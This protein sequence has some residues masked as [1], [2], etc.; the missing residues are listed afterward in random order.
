MADAHMIKADGNLVLMH[1]TAEKER[2]Y[3]LF[4]VHMP[5]SEEL[6]FL[7]RLYDSK[8]AGGIHV[9][10]KPQGAGGMNVKTEIYEKP[11]DA[12]RRCEEWLKPV[13]VVPELVE[14][15]TN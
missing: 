14:P 11:L 7:V 8:T 5:A 1:A 15:E 13:V 12:M 2:A 4:R 6:L 9:P 3:A 10:G